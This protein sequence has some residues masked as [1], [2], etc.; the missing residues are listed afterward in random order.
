M[1]K[2]SASLIL[3]GI[4]LILVGAAQPRVQLIDADHSAFSYFG[5]TDRS[6][7]KAVR[8]DWPGVYLRCAFTGNTLELRLKG[9]TRDYY[10]VFVDNQPVKVIHSLTDS[11][12][13]IGGFSGK[14]NHELLLTKRTE[15]DMGVLTVNIDCIRPIF[16]LQL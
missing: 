8:F 16:K 9:G 10:N 11:V 7:P 15:G 14:G 13:A 5:R 4:F 3:A 6:D 1:L 2:R 12:F